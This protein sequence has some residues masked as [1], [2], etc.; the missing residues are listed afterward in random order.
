MTT[1][2]LKWDSPDLARIT[3]L[4][5]VK[6]ADCYRVAYCSG[7]TAEGGKVLVLLPFTKLPRK[8]LRYAI[9]KYAKRAGVYAEGLNIFDAID[10]GP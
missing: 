7:E 2:L 10:I 6:S 1:P 5:L 9:V 3:V 4:Q 8:G